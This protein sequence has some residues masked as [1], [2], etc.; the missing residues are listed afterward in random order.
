MALCVGCIAVELLYHLAGKGL[1]EVHRHD[2][3]ELTVHYAVNRKVE[4]NCDDG[5]LG[6]ELCQLAE[7]RLLDQVGRGGGN[8]H[9]DAQ[10][11]GEC[12][13]RST[14][15]LVHDL[16]NGAYVHLVELKIRR[17]HQRVAHQLVEYELNV[18]LL[19]HHHVLTGDTGNIH[20]LYADRRLKTVVVKVGSL[21]H[22][23]LWCRDPDLCVEQLRNC[24]CSRA[25]AYVEYLAD[26]VY[27]I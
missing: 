24:G 17:N 26:R 18:V 13:R 6:V 27:F 8:I 1:C 3:H 14:H 23:H 19:E 22:T 20:D 12:S 25:H 2:G 4:C 9:G 5:L 15:H 10:Q 16:G 11:I 21:D 7:V